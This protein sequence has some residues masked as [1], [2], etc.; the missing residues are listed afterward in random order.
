MWGQLGHL[1]LD[2]AGPA[3]LLGHGCVNSPCSHCLI[4]AQTLGSSTVGLGLRA[5]WTFQE[6]VD[7]RRA[8]TVCQVS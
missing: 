4:T 5:V 2:W 7:I 3:D 1:E 6:L 8:L